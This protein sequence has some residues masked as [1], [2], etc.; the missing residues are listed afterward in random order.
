MECK[1]DNGDVTTTMPKNVKCNI[2]CDTGYEAV[3]D[4]SE[5]K[6]QSSGVWDRTVYPSCAKIN[7][8]QTRTVTVDFSFGTSYCTSTAEQS[9]M[10]TA[11]KTTLTDTTGVTCLKNKKCEV[12]EFSCASTGSDSFKVSFKLNQ[13]SD[14]SSATILTESAAEIEAVKDSIEFSV[15]AAK[16]KKSNGIVKRATTITFSPSGTTINSQVTGCKNNQY[17]SSNQ[18]V[19]CPSGYYL[20]S[21]KCSACA[22]GYYAGSSGATSCTKCSD[23][24]T[25]VAMGS[26]AKTQCTKTCTVP[27]VDNSETSTIPDGT[28]VEEGAVVYY[29]CKEGYI[30]AN[31]SVFTCAPD[32]ATVTPVCENENSDLMWYLI[33][34]C[35]GVL[36]LAIILIIIFCCA[37]KLRKD[38]DDTS[39]SSSSSGTP[40]YILENKY[41][42]EEEYSPRENERYAN[43]ETY[44]NRRGNEKV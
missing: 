38:D 13:L 3:G 15:S 1:D 25:T 34:I 32:Y 26:T 44:K 10:E 23:G 40:S 5:L 22:K 20:D 37:L 7:V 12:T 39:S 8:P 43:A 36:L 16:K 21:D 24:Y 19:E 41:A 27:D 28:T 11:V 17:L 30:M 33:G 18:C 14:L 35:G 9:K 31:V 42:N 2:K 29:T 4:T 6:C